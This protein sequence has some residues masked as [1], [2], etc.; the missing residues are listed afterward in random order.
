MELG[1]LL[2]LKREAERLRAKGEKAEEGCQLQDDKGLKEW[3]TRGNVI[4][5]C[6]GIGLMDVVIGGELVRMARER[7][8]GTTIENF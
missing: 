1:E 6:V 3:L 5:K 8:I 2:M 4:F 7:G